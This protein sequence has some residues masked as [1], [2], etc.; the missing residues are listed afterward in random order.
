M[1]PPPGGKPTAGH[2]GAWI[3]FSNPA[4]G[5]GVMRALART[6]P[7]VRMPACEPLRTVIFDGECGFC[8]RAIQ[9]GKRLDWGHRMEWRARLERGLLEQFPQLSH[10]GTQR[11]MVSIRPDG[12]TYGGFFAVR[13]IMRHLPLTVLPA[14]LLF[15]PGVSWVGVPLYQWVAS[16]RY[17]FSGTGDDHCPV[18]RGGHEGG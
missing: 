18:R 7:R 2:K 5:G 10:E 15:L 4:P 6:F 12:T 3:A 16:H 9:L 13:D 14:L 17:R 11:R 8:L 1:T